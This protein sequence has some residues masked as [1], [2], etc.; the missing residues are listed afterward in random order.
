[1]IHSFLH[2]LNMYPEIF[3]LQMSLKKRK[4]VYEI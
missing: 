4:Y 1:M 2:A 3:Y